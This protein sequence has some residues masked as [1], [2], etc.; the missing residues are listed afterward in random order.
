MINEILSERNY[1]LETMEQITGQYQIDTRELKKQISEMNVSELEANQQALIYAVNHIA[2]DQPDWT[3]VAA[4]FYLNE[5]YGKSAISR[6][7]HHSLKYGDF[8]Q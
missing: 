2:M 6:G 1:V 8:Y 4:R 7:Y 5:L 3:Y